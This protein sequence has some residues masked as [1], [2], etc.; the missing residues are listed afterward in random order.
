MR[1]I[2][3]VALACGTALSALPAFAQ[4]V[5]GAKDASLKFTTALGSA[6]AATASSFFTDDAVALPPG[7][8][9]ISG[10]PQIQQ[11]LGNMTRSVKNLKYTSESLTPINDTTAREVG[12][13]SFTMERQGKSNDV[14]GKYLLIWTKAGGD[15]KISADMWNRSS[16]GGGKGGAKRSGSGA[17]GA[18]TGG[19]T[20]PQ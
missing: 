2:I 5:S 7:R 12:S 19:D 3:A 17:G 11:F 15:W 14:S 8:A 4:D 6:D 16:S 9:E 1:N 20:D 18:G 13:F 10:R